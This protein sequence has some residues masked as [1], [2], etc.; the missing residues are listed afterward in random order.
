MWAVGREPHLVTSGSG[1]IALFRKGMSG[2]APS[3]TKADEAQPDES[4]HVIFTRHT[5]VFVISRAAPLDLPSYVPARTQSSRPPQTHVSPPQLSPP[6][7]VAA[8]IA[9][10]LISPQDRVIHIFHR[11]PP[12]IHSDSATPEEQHG[13][14]VA[15]ALQPDTPV[16]QRPTGPPQSSTQPFS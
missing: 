7:Q 13:P 12:R 1:G 5:C 8:T 10:G 3:S 11:P 16:L 2:L 14:I 15:P 6:L 9:D 4:D